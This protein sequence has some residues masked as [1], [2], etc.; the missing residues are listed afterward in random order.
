MLDPES[1]REVPVVLVR[2]RQHRPSVAPARAGHDP[3]AGVSRAPYEQARRRTAAHGVDGALVL[4]ARELVQLRL[5]RHDRRGGRAGRVQ[6]PATRG[7]SSATNEAWRGWSGEQPGA[8]AFLRHGDRVFHT[9]SLY[10]RGLDMLMGTYHWLDLTARGRQEDWEEPKAAQRQPGDGL[11]PPPRP[12]RPGLG[13]RSTGQRVRT[14]TPSSVTSTVCSNCAVRAPSAVTAV[15]PSSQMTG[16]DAAHRDH[17]LDGEHHARLEDGAAPP[18]RS[19][20]APAAGRGTPRR[21]RG[22]RTCAPRRS[23]V[24]CAWCSMARPMSDSGAPGRTASIARSR[25]SSVT[26]TRRFELAG[27]PGRR[28][29]WRWCRRARRRRRR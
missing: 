24:A 26:C 14:S 28:R 3:R 12:V 10:S 29:R 19:S 13:A 16:L 22:R 2:R 4:V 11:A 1:G 5:P 7:S 9:Y 15:H 20:A 6:L 18:A 17:G 27:R 25:H 21:C 8:S 23:R